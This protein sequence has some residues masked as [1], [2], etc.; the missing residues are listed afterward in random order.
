M[1]AG[2]SDE[3]L[4]LGNV[5]RLLMARELKPG[6]PVWKRLPAKIRRDLSGKQ[7]IEVVAA[8][9]IARALEGNQ[10]AASLIF[11]WAYSL[12]RT[13]LDLTSGG[14]PIKVSMPEE[15]RR[16]IDALLGPDLRRESDEV[17]RH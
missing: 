9:L 11:K 2:P 10:D 8:V 7:P 13:D 4:S 6:Q 16:E 17:T 15:I 12:P 5:I 14:E 3:R 1:A